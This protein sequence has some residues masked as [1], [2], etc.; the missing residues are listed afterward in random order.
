MQLSTN[1]L[2]GHLR[3]QSWEIFAPLGRRLSAQATDGLA[4]LSYYSESIGLKESP[5]GVG[6]GIANA[7]TT[8]PRYVLQRFGLANPLSETCS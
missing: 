1:S 8:Q 6:Q 7:F 4:A 5:T 3:L 2:C